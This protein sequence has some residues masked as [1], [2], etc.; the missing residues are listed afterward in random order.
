MIKMTCSRCG[1]S[2]YPQRQA[3]CPRCLTVQWL[4]TPNLI[5][6]HRTTAPP[7]EAHPCIRSTL[8]IEMLDDESVFLYYAASNGI[9]YYHSGGCYCLFVPA[10]VGIIPGVAIPVCGPVPNYASTRLLMVDSFGSNPRAFICDPEDFQ[11]G[12]ASGLYK[13]LP[14]CE[15]PGCENLRFPGGKRCLQHNRS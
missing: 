4:S 2:W 3:Q 13:P 15:L 8:S 12:V 10:P 5:T 11:A 9:I 14:K 7:P 1:S 6:S